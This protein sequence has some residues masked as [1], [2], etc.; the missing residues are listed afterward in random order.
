MRAISFAIVGVAIFATPSFAFERG[1]QAEYDQFA[2][3]YGQQVGAANA[4][5][6]DYENWVA[7][8]PNPDAGEQEMI[9]SAREMMVHLQTLAEASAFGFEDLDHP[10]YGMDFNSANKAYSKGYLFWERYLSIP[11]IDRLIID[12]TETELGMT[13]ACFGIASRILALHTANI[14]SGEL[15]WDD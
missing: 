6:D 11:F 15:V 3:C 4:L 8:Y 13:D 7:V 12:Y 14:A 1:T 5:A 10:G 2:F 9:D